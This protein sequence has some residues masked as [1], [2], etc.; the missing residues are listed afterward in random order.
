[1]ISDETIE[2]WKINYGLDTR[3]PMDAAKWWSDNF[4][5]MAPAGA[6]AALG[7]AIIE[8]ERIQNETKRI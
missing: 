1:M 7:C 2:C 8:I 5:G 6:V 3:N 4:N